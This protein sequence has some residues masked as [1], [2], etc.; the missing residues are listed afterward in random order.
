MN[1]RLASNASSATVYALL[2]IGILVFTFLFQ[3]TVT[4][5]RV[6]ALSAT[7]F[8]PGKIID[9]EVFYNKN[10]MNTQQIQDFLNQLLPSCDTWGT[11]RSEYGGGTRAQYAASQG[12]SG[13]PYVCL[14]NY[15]ENPQ[16]NETSYERGGGAFAGGLSAAQII[17]NAAQQYGINPQ[18]LLVLLKKESAG[19]LTADSWPLKSQYR[20]S[21]GYGCPDSGPGYS[22][23]CDGQ[24]SGFYKQVNYAAWQLKYYKDH[25]N[26]YRYRIGSNQIQY[27]PDPACGVKS[28]NIQN[29]ATLSLY[30]YT[31]YV[32]NDAALRNYP[33][34][35]PCGAYGNRNFY[36]FF[37]E[38]F[39]STNFNGVRDEKNA[40]WRL[41][42]PKTGG[43]ML[44]ADYTEVNT[45]LANNWKNDG[46]VS[47]SVENGTVPIHR[48]YNSQSK[49]HTIATAQ[50]A[51]S[52]RSRGWIDDGVIFKANSE[53]TPVWRISNQGR[54]FLTS[55]ANEV[56]TYRQ[57]GWN[58]DG[59]LYYELS[60]YETQTWRL[61]NRVTGFH[62]FVSNVNEL[63]DYMRSGWI[64]D[65]VT[66]S[67]SKEDTVPV[68][69]L[70]N[71]RSHF[72]TAN[73]SEK[74]TYI[75]GGWKNDGVIFY[76]N[77]IQL[78]YRLY[79][80]A[81]NSHRV[82]VSMDEFHHNL[83]QGWKND[84]VI[85]KVSSSSNLPIYELS[86]PVT[87]SFFYTAN[88]QEVNAYTQNGWVSNGIKFRALNNGQ[89][90]Y[91][92]YSRTT[93][94]H[95]LIQNESEKQAYIQAGWLDDGV[96]FS[97]YR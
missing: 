32:P 57:H 50:E 46:V 86:N 37:K 13:P 24:K 2:G 82:V 35:A 69:R 94:T 73:E 64:N 12:W 54:Y 29:I 44:S 14:K 96:I 41:Y 65:G 39:G 91:R 49:Y 51:A 26:D 59:V 5:A 34:T 97:S 58:I 21:M 9:D 74:D 80:P 18:V 6:Q 42:N 55:N 75:R 67:G 89:P 30:I 16:T 7:E 33:G 56:A 3:V 38:W 40:V 62:T 78:T 19:P 83:K 48:L 81:T 79:N 52:L 76:T 66:I 61:Y 4:P 88:A 28:V 1:K 68:Y 93:N 84:G 87:N 10:S 15:H 31:P 92:L 17:Y 36:M 25:P 45:Y 47:H 95:I 70:W 20:Y 72:V 77:N 53:G 22:A 27:A 90:V 63:T 23:N 43:H 11:G 85:F 71:G 60:S 8:N